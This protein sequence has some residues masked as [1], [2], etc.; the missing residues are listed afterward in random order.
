MFSATTMA[1]STTMPITSTN[2]NRHRLL[3]DIPSP[4]ITAKVP[5]SETGMVMAGISVAR[6]SCRKIQTVRITSRIAM[7]R[8]LITSAIEASM[9]SVAS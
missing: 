5:I 2:P 7:I 1:S 9:Y 6:Q 4:S 8:V 3:I